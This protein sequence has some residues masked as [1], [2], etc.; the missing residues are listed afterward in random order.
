MPRTGLLHVDKRK[1]QKRPASLAVRAEVVTR[2]CW[3]VGFWRTFCVLYLNIR[4]IDLKG[5]EPVD[6]SW[7]KEFLLTYGS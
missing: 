6:L 2:G 1:W 3:A 7:V 5:Q 4:I